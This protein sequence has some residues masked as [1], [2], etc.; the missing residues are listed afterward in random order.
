MCLVARRAIDVSAV[1]AVYFL[2]R[3]TGTS[4]SIRVFCLPSHRSQSTTTGYS[5]LIVNST[6]Y[7]VTQVNLSIHLP[8]LTFRLYRM[9]LVISD[10][11]DC[12]IKPALLDQTHC[13]YSCK[14]E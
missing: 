6:N 11:S 4:L 9:D 2:R 1:N 13:V 5:Q 8:R 3:L 10:I 14:A 7:K 12:H